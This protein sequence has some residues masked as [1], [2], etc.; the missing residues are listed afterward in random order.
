MRKQC[1]PGAF[2]FLARAEDEAMNP[3]V[4]QASF[5]LAPACSLDTF[6][7]AKASLHTKGR[8]GRCCTSLLRSVVHMHMGCGHHLV[9]V[10]SEDHAFIP[11]K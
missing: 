3:S 2:P 7:I 11:Q 1:V 4:Q 9:G 6:V 10:W 8:V 5:S